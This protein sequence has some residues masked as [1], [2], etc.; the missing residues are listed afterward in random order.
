MQQ[1][2]TQSVYDLFNGRIQFLVPVYERAY[3]WNRGRELGGS[4]G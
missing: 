1:P 2:T 3:V 4:L